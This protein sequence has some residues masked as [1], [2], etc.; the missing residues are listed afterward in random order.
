MVRHENTIFQVGF[1]VSIPFKN[2]CFSSAFL[3]F[4][5][6]RGKRTHTGV[7]IGDVVG[8]VIPHFA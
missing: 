5:I 2:C 7:L 1:S 4:S 8:N 3:T 6:R